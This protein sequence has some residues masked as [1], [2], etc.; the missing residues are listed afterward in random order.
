MFRLS[1]RQGMSEPSSRWRGR[2]VLVTGCTGFLGG[3]VVEEL[4]ARGS[5]VIGL[6]RD[7]G[8]AAVLARHQL[9][10]RV[11]I[12]HGRCEDLF[13][14]HSALAIHEAHAVFHLAACEP[15]D[16]DGGTATVLEAIRRFDPRIPMVVARRPDAL[17]LA[18]SP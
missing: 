7:R 12:V 3:A 11:R 14:I 9:A 17:A 4:L 6:V 8:S 10:G 15:L 18:D 1:T 5:Q 16:T 2:R 13:R